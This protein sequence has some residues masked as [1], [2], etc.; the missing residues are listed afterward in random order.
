MP[1]PQRPVWKKRLTIGA[2][3]AEMMK[4]VIEKNKRIP[5]T[6]AI[7]GYYQQVFAIPHSVSGKLNRSLQ[8]K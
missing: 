1:F 8:I 2:P 3:G 4:Q 5:E 7:E 6:N